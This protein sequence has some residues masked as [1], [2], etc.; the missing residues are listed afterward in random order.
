M[1][2]L[3]REERRPR[4]WSVEEFQRI[5][6]AGIFGPE[7]RVE[8]IE[9]EILPVS[10]EGPEHAAVNALLDPVL[11]RAFGKGFYLRHSNPIPLEKFSQ[12]E[13]DIAV[14]RGTPRDHMSAHPKTAELVV[15]VSFTSRAFDRGRKQRLYSRA[16]V[17]EYWI[18]DLVERCLF[19]YRDPERTGYASL[20][21]QE[22]GSFVR[23]LRAKRRIAVADL[24][25]D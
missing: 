2:E 5:A 12:P 15:E 19:V 23:P 21:R 16:G 24:L 6:D 22:A 7:E 9:G 11:R 13:P 10:P 14:V 17:P 20:T 3:E 25:P 4:R 8:L 18:V 1:D